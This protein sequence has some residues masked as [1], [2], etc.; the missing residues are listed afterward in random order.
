MSIVKANTILPAEATHD[1]TLGAS[2][3]TVTVAADSIG[4]NT[5]KDKGGNILWTSDGAGN[6]SN[7]NA[8]LT[9]NEILLTTNTFTSASSSEFTSKID[10]TYDVYIF[11]MYDINPSANLSELRFQP[12]SNLGMSYGMNITSTAWHAYNH[13]TSGAEGLE[14]QTGQDL[15]ETPDPQQLCNGL[16]N[17]ADESLAGEIYL[18]AP[19]ST[20]YMKHFQSRVQFYQG[21][22][23]S[24]DFFIAGYIN[25]TLAVN[26]IQFTMDSGT[27]DG[28]IKMYGLL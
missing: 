2:G 12:S 6:V 19:S 28:T 21:S 25:S 27:F 7:V 3:D 26:A 15:A 20:T 4:V 13:E 1:I 14:Y 22:D 24:E 16:G 23:Y 10:S 9:G 5:V 18:Y 11:R 17:L 8:A